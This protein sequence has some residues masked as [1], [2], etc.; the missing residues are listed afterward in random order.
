MSIQDN[1]IDLA[2]V[3][4]FESD[5]HL[6]YQ[7]LS[8]KLRPTVRTKTG[9]VGKQTTFQTI[10]KATASQKARNGEVSLNNIDHTPVPCTLQD[11]Y[12]AELVDKLDELKINHNERQAVAT[13]LA[14]ALGRKDDE[15]ITNVMTAATVA[16][17]NE[18]VDTGGMTLP[19]CETVF[20]AMGNADV[21]DDGQR[22]LIVG[23]Q[24]WTDLMNISQFSNADYIGGDELPYPMI[25]YAAKRWF[26]FIVMPF[27]GLP[28]AGNVRSCFAYHSSA[29]G[30]ASQ[31]DIS[32]DITW[33]GKNQGH[34]F[35]GSMATGA[36]QIDA[37]GLWNIKCTES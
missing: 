32:L 18:T 13:S 20:E 21:P 5:Y 36:C 26:S 2:F 33:Q 31:A 1:T 19:K 34:L 28:K 37:A 15:L 17:G 9:I 11:W 8:A 27:S 24:Q 25:G 35:V 10:G 23:P 4:Q 30:H 22:Y 3:E 12:S 14:A 16:S 29:V 7:R 6:A